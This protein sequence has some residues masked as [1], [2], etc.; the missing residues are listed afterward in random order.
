[1]ST[2]SRPRTNYLG[3]DVSGK[4]PEHSRVPGLVA[5]GERDAAIWQRAKP[6]LRVRDNDAHSL[7]SYAIAHA[8]VAQVD[9]A[10]ENIVLPAILLH[11]TGWSTVNEQDAL[12]AISPGHDGSLRH[13]IVQHEVEGARIA[14]EILTEVGV[15]AADIDE[16]VEIIAGHDTRDEALSINDALVK[17][18][19]KVWRVTP[20]A[21]RVV[22]DW[23]GLNA[24]QSLRLC[25][26]RAHD[27]LFTEAARTMS[28]ALV[29]IG[30][31]DLTDQMA[32]TYVRE[33]TTR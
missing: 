6:F 24:D 3:R 23:F 10:H 17:D 11:D 8:L 14:R 13:L 4:V 1:M 18:A 20:H 21:R 31:M 25:A 28:R 22:M 26:Y 5:L 33:G 19:D 30:S 27:E 16:I 32:D 29:A 12:E 15:P 2:A 9:G 7:Y